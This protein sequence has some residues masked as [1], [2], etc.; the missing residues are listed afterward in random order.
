MTL[1]FELIVK[2]S[3][4]YLLILFVHF[5]ALGRYLKTRKYPNIGAYL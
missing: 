3:D 4:F 2:M 1:I 5:I